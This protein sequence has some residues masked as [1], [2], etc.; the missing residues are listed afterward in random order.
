MCPGFS[1]L[2]GHRC[3]VLVNHFVNWSSLSSILRE[4]HITTADAQGILLGRSHRAKMTWVTLLLFA[5][6]N[7]DDPLL[8]LKL[9]DNMVMVRR[10]GSWLATEKYTEVSESRDLDASS[11]CTGCSP[12]QSW[13]DLHPRIST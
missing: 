11:S 5:P 12:G 7:S 13:E 3:V 4:H 2:G 8:P 9:P 10:V 1:V 6:G